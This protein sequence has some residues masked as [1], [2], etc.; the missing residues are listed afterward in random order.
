MHENGGPKFLPI[1][2]EPLVGVRVDAED[3]VVFRAVPF[4]LVILVL[5]LPVEQVEGGEWRF[6]SRRQSR[7]RGRSRRPNDIWFSARFYEE[8]VE[9]SF[10]LAPRDDDTTRDAFD[11]L[12][13]KSATL[14]L[15]L[16]LCGRRHFEIQFV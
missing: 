16:F 15:S 12:L 8:L 10:P 1:D 2:F 9:Q 13:H 5:V 3:V 14:S 7:R 11:L 4:L 6:V